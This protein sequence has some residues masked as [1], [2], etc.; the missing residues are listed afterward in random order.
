MGCAA[1][2]GEYPAGAPPLGISPESQFPNHTFNLQGGCLYLYTDGL[3][4]ARIGDRRLE[5]E[6]L[7]R[8]LK[9]YA[10]LPLEARIDAISNAVKAVDG[11]VDDDL[12]LLI[13]E[14]AR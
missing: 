7:L 11:I 10:H 13:I 4:E 3:L 8:L 9:E 12:T 5:K 2:I 1:M 6:G 14:E